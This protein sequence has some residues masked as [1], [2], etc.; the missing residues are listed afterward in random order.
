VK[1]KRLNF[2][3]HK[4]TAFLLAP[5]LATLSVFWLYPLFHAL[6]LSFT[7]YYT[8]KNEAVFIGWANY[9][10]I[11]QDGFFYTALQNT[12]VFAL[13]TI[14]LTT[15][16]ALGLAVTLN[17][18]RHGQAFFRAAFFLPSVTS[19]IVMTLIFTNVYA[20]DGYLTFLCKTLGL[21]FPVRGWLQEP[22]TALAAIMAMD[23]L[24]STGYYMVLLL[25]ALQ[26]IPRDLYEAAE[27]AGAKGWAVFSRITVPML[28]PTLLF[29][30]VINTIRSFQIFVEIYVMTRGGP[31][32]STSTLIYSVYVNAFDRS[33]MMGYACALAYIVFG[34]I[35]VFSLAQMWLLRLN[36]SS[37]S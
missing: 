9:A 31:L 1:S 24:L 25:A 23:V 19:L 10:H 34:I 28:R 15:A 12:A 30:L 33:D 32:G 26:A 29:V 27:L 16:L 13:G 22:S 35:L 2:A 21:P 4:N 36:Q 14:P 5:W 18:I 3:M 7:K 17:S 6:Y 20:S 11:L 8:L 37:D